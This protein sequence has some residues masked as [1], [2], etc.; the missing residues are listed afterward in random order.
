[1]LREIYPRPVIAE[2]LGAWFDPQ[3]E[4]LAEREEADYIV[5]DR[6]RTRRSLGFHRVYPGPQVND[7][8]FEV[9]RIYRRPP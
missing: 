8:D 5:I 6:S 3:L 2:G 7:A 1:M 4:Y 9:Y